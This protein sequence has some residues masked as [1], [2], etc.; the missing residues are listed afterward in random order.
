M[1]DPEGGGE[2]LYGA[3]REACCAL[4]V[5]AVRQESCHLS[6]GLAAAVVQSLKVPDGYIRCQGLGNPKK[7]SALRVETVK[8]YGICTFLDKIIVPSAAQR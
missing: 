4:K 8:K 5:P 3:W 7:I 1:Q 2:R 6:T